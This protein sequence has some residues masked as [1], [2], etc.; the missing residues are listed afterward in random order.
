MWKQKVIRK[1]WPVLVKNIY[2]FVC[3]AATLCFVQLK[4][5]TKHRVAAELTKLYIFLLQ[6]NISKIV[7]YKNECSKIKDCSMSFVRYLTQKKTNYYYTYFSGFL[8][9]LNIFQE[10]NYV[11]NTRASQQH[12]SHSHSRFL[13]VCPILLS[14]HCWIIHT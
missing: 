6:T 11:S 7:F 10:I 3:S 12:M 2:N 1:Y 13:S 5:Y 14:P 8:C 9:L 4:L